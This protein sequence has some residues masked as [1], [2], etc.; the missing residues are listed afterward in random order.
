MDEVF[1]TIVAQNPVTSR[2]LTIDASRPFDNTKMEWLDDVTSPLSWTVTTAYTAG[3]GLV[4]TTDT[5]G[6]EEGMIVQFELASGVRS[7]LV[8]KV[9][10]IVANT[11]FVI[12]VYGGSTDQNLTVGSKIQLLD[13]PAIEGSDASRGNGFE[14]VANYNYSQ[15]MDEFVTLTWTAYNSKMYGINKTP[16]DIINY[17]LEKKIQMLAYKIGAT[18][19]N[20]PRVIGTSTTAGTMG[21]WLW[22]LKNTAGVNSVNGAGAITGDILNQG[23]EK[24]K[25]KGGIGATIVAHPVQAKRLSALNTAGA[26]PIVQIMQDSVTA[27]Q[28]VERFVTDF[29]DVASIVY[30]YDMDKDKIAIIDP[31]KIT[32]RPFINDGFRDMDATTPGSR[33]LSRRI[34]GQYSLEMKNVKE[35][36]ALITNLTV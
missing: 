11:S 25:E 13:L 1:A 6:L 19:I 36:H 33:T 3:A 12:T 27:G 5:T 24:I 18:T 16:G 21:G 4:L 32:L 17:L 14:P 7:T 15:I 23:F 28:Y 8:A 22:F 20:M 31:S 2:L 26:N 35:S 9:G 34:T 30:S 29:G 10:T